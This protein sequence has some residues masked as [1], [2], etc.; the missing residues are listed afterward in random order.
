MLIQAGGGG[1]CLTLKFRHQYQK[2]TGNNLGQDGLLGQI[3]EILLCKES[4]Y[5]FTQLKIYNEFSLCET[6]YLGV[7]EYKDL[8]Y[9]I[10]FLKYAFNLMKQLIT[11]Y[12]DNTLTYII[13]LSYNNYPVIKGLDAYCNVPVWITYWVFLR[14]HS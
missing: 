4:V 1:G 11:S 5:L 3:I 13:S 8:S 2:A 6:S 7:Q 10:L 12:I 9:S 14:S